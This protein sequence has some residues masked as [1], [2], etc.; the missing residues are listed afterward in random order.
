MKVCTGTGGTGIV[1]VPN[2]PK[3]PV[4]VLMSYRS[5]RSIPCQC[6]SRTELIE[7]SGT[8]IGAALNLPKC[9]VPVLM[10][11]T[12]LTE[13]SGTGMKVCTGT[14]G[15]GIHVVPNLSK[16]SVTGIDVVSK[17]LKCPVPGIS[18][19]YT[20]GMPRYVPYRTHTSNFLSIPVYLT[21]MVR[22]ISIDT[23]LFDQYVKR[24]TH[25]RRIGIYVKSLIDTYLLD[26]HVQRC[27]DRNVFVW[28]TRSEKLVQ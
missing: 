21:N 7:V 22:W 2:S 8:G 19:V 10:L 14:G 11:Y 23:C 5:Y 3:Y 13:V 17:L 6:W 20:T 16:V 9:P 28:S 24:T 18:A 1:V 12:K 26:R 25:K 15:T 4:P 27:S